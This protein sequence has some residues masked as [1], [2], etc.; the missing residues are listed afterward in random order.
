[1][2]RS[3]VCVMMLLWG[4]IMGA[5][6]AVAA[7]SEDSAAEERPAVLIVVGAPGTE[8]YGSE[9]EAWA[10]SWETAA[11]EGGA[12]VTRIGPGSSDGAGDG[13]TDRERLETALE[14][15]AGPSA[16]ALWL[17]L[18]GH[19]TF[20][21]REAKFNLRGPDVSAAELCGWLEPCK[22]KLAIINCASASGP[23]INSLSGP[24]RI[25][26]T[27]TKSGYE[28]NYARFGGYLAD[29]MAQRDVDLDKD[30][31][32]SLLEGFL[33][34]SAR[35]A[36]FYTEEARLATEHALIDD[37]GDGLGTPAEWFRGVRVTRRTADGRVPDGARASQLI[38]V[39][40]DS[41]PTLPHAARERRDELELSLERLRVKKETLDEATY[42]ARLEAIL[43]ELARLYEG[44]DPDASTASGP[45][46]GEG[47]A[48]APPRSR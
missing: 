26:I 42:Y 21:G 4:L 48:P 31:Q 32:S 17:V 9:F 39:R 46:D 7:P 30:G 35:T 27:A 5:C 34:A 45:A 29:A 40:D 12:E 25:I 10:G 3:P 1:M 16:A 41:V 47:G 18:L 14:A 11:R 22:R 38:L 33:V 37:N 28:Y 24:G 19:G 6:P 8:D 43:L 2:N 20:D 23:F 13:A 36:E 15:S 44:L